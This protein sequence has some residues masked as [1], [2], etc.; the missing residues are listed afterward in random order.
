MEQETAELL[1]EV[2]AALR[3]ARF[4]GADAVAF[5]RIDVGVAEAEPTAAGR[6]APPR[7]AGAAA[8]TAR[9]ASRPETSGGLKPRGRLRTR[10]DAAGAAAPTTGPKRAQSGQKLPILAFATGDTNGPLTVLCAG[11]WG[12]GAGAMWSGPEG[13][14]LSRMIS[15]MKLNPQT[16]HAVTLVQVPDGETVEAQNRPPPLSVQLRESES[17]ALLIFGDRAAQWLLQTR[18]SMDSLRGK[19]R[20][21]AGRPAMVTYGP[22]VLLQMPMYKAMAWKDMQDVMRTL[23][24]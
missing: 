3:W 22:E 2:A 16:V 10:I 1:E 4:G 8:A 6:S 12:D 19:W 13:E 24:I 23:K 5:E 21:L 7:T 14:L 15:A 17:K 20:T 18:E 11:K 9:N